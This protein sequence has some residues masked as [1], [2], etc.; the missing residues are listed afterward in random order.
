MT[1]NKQKSYFHCWAKACFALWMEYKLSHLV[2]SRLRC[3]IFCVFV[4]TRVCRMK[5]ECL[6]VCVIFTWCA[7]AHVSELC[8][9][10]SEHCV[11]V[12]VPFEPAACWFE[13]HIP[14]E[15]MNV[16]GDSHQAS[17]Y[18]QNVHCLLCVFV[19]SL[20][21]TSTRVHKSVCA[22]HLVDFVVCLQQFF[23]SSSVCVRLCLVDQQPLFNAGPRGMWVMRRWQWWVLGNQLLRRERGISPHGNIK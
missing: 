23:V 5:V 12:C 1:E 21:S 11:F 6:L 15:R 18:W 13:A 2:T 22:Q 16:A 4:E 3:V 8:V 17:N 14:S 20:G 19:C 10:D 9:C 7:F